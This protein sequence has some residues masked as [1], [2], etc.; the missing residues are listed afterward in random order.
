M[1]SD[2]VGRRAVS[3]V[4][5]ACMDIAGKAYGVPVYRLLGGPLRD[6]IPCYANGWYKGERTPES[7]AELARGVVALGHTALKLDPF[8]AA[9]MLASERD[10][11]EAA[12][13]V[14][15]IREAVGPEVE[16]YVDAHGRFT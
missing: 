13:L 1:R 5:V 8:G 15:A 11:R 3:G 14:A 12:E 10:V 6:R 4:L 7:Y 16:I 9:G 2:I